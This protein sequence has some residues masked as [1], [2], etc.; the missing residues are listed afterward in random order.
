MESLRSWRGLGECL[1][2]FASGQAGRR[3]SFQDAWDL[4]LAFVGGGGWGGWVGWV[5]GV[6]WGGVWGRVGW[7]VG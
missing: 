1:Q 5:G 3:T 6:G 2:G 4:L 7:G